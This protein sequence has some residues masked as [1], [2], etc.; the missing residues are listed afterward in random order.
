M[1]VSKPVPH[2]DIPSVSR[3]A[4]GAADGLVTSQQDLDHKTGRSTKGFKLQNSAYQRNGVIYFDI[5]NFF[6][7]QI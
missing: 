6:L 7:C 3:F 4:E 1:H 5:P 2:K